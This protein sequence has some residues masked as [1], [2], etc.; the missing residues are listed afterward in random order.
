MILAVNE[1]HIGSIPLHLVVKVAIVDVRNRHARTT[2]AIGCDQF[3][4]IALSK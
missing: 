1:H 2:G 3:S 4:A